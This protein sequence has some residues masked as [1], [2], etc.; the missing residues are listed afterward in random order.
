MD[1]VEDNS[2]LRRGAPGQLDLPTG[3]SQYPCSAIPVLNYASLLTSR[4][5]NL[6]CPSDNKQCQLCLFSGIPGD[7]SVARL[8]GS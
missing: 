4:S 1:D 3:N 2:Q 5:Q 6:W 8:D 7:L